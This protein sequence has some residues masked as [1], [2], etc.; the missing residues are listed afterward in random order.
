MKKRSSFTLLAGLLVFTA[1]VLSTGSF[2]QKNKRD[3]Y[4]MTIYHFQTPEQETVLNLYLEKALIPALHRLHINPVGVFKNMANDTSADK[5]MYVLISVPSLDKLVKM[6]ESIQKDPEYFR[7]GKDYT[8]ALYSNP[9]YTRM[10]N[11]LLKAFPLAGQLKT[12]QLKSPRNERVYELRSY[13]SATEKIFKN[14]V[15]MFNEGGEIDLFARLQFN[16]IFYSEVVAGSKM[17]NLMYMTS[18]EN[19]ADRDAH[20]KTFVA[21]P[22][23]KEL[24]GRPE[25]QK[26]VSHI[27]IS[28]LRPLEY[29]DY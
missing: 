18:F 24:S 29:S 2:A 22:F 17:P 15:H 5:K 27:D 26:N 9:P 23:W 13:E 6:E 20:W 1:Q 11:I 3:F 14:K 7:N 21:D 28:F 4:Q 8:E 19:M 10:E 16:A 25:Y 12:P